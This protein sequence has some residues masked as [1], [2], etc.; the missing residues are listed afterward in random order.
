M[1]LSI[2][3]GQETNFSKQLQ[4]SSQEGLQQQAE[5]PA[6]AG[7]LRVLPGESWGPS[8]VCSQ[9]TK[10]CLSCRLAALSPVRTRFSRAH[11]T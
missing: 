8:N 9:L 2:L 5:C 11:T 6:F 10:M 7:N 4:S 1:K 3:E